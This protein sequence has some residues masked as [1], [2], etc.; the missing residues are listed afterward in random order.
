[1]AFASP[2]VLHNILRFRGFYQT[3]PKYLYKYLCETDG[4]PLAESTNSTV[5]T[6]GEIFTD[7]HLPAVGV[8]RLDV[9]NTLL[10]RAKLHD[11]SCITK[12]KLPK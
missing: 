4:G 3:W 6:I 8:K 11:E 1:M 2:L 12:N 10:K 9:C 5:K 7:M